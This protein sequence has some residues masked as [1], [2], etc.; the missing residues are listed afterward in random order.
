MSSPV[1]GRSPSSPCCHAHMHAYNH[2]PVLSE[3]AVS[4]THQRGFSLVSLFIFGCF[5][6]K[7]FPWFSQNFG[8][9]FTDSAQWSEPN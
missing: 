4:Q 3:R 9:R 7:M 2:S 6:L 5:P 1:E 8:V